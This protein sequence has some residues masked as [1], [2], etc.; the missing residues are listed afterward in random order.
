MMNADSIVG[1]SV[2]PTAF[3]DSDLIAID[4]ACAGDYWQANAL[5]FHQG[6]FTGQLVT[7]NG[8]E[9]MAPTMQRFKSLGAFIDRNADRLSPATPDR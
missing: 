7:V 2:S 4:G 9:V 6:G 5:K 3:A 8:S 1:Q